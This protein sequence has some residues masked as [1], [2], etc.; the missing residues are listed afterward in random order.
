MRYM[1]SSFLIVLMRLIMSIMH[2]LHE[3]YKAI[4]TAHLKGAHPVFYMI[5]INRSVN[6]GDWE[7]IFRNLPNK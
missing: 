7:N 2:A 6:W 5:S 1:V 4:G 3:H